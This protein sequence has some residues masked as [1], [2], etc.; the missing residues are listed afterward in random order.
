MAYWFMTSCYIHGYY[1]VLTVYLILVYALK[2][3]CICITITG[4]ILAH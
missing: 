4:P 2:V 1:D 3:M